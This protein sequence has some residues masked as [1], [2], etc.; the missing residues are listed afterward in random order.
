MV[1]PVLLYAC[2]C[3]TLTIQR[4]RRHDFKSNDMVLREAGQRQVICI[5]PERQ[6]RL[7]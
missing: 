2:E 4:K 6:L 1:L 7:Y 3:L 5:V